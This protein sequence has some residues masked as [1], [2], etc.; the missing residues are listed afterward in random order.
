MADTANRGLGS[1]NM[2]A[3]TK[4]DI[5]SE[6]GKASHGGEHTAGQK[7][8]QTST[9]HTG[10]QGLGSDT[11]DPQTKHDIQSEGGKASHGE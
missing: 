2:D 7:G 9:S 10:K 4:H 1:D 3:Q 8:G 6:G 5:Q 11:I